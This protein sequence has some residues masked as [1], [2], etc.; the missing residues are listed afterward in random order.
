MTIL[1]MVTVRA[2]V[3]QASNATKAKAA[4]LIKYFVLREDCYDK[5][6]NKQDFSDKE[7]IKFTL[8]KTIGFAIIVGSA[9]VKLPQI[10]K[11]VVNG[12]VKGISSISYYIEVSAS[13]FNSSN[14]FIDNYLHANCSYCFF[15]GP[16]I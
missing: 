4:P 15:K 9:I 6:V 10:I 1:A 8:S 7:C 11:I 3:E 5:F 2:E 12:S 13:V 14:S 16:S